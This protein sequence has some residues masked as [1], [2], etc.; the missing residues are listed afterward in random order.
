MPQAAVSLP[1]AL[2]KWPFSLNCSSQCSPIKNGISR[3]RTIY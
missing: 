3:A 1:P 2:S